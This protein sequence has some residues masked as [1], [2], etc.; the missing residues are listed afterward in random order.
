M[1]SLYALAN[2][3]ITKV[4]ETYQVY[5]MDTLQ[6]MTYSIEKNKADKDEDAFQEQMR[7]NRKGK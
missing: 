4:A 3:E 5:L 1:A 6:F 2:E 7:K